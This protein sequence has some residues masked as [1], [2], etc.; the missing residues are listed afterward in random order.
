M[1]ALRGC[2]GGWEGGG[3]ARGE[4][5]Y[6]PQGM[7]LSIPSTYRPSQGLLL[8][9]PLLYLPPVHPVLERCLPLVSPRLRIIVIAV[10]H[11][12]FKLQAV[13]SPVSLSGLLYAPA[14]ADDVVLLAVHTLLHLGLH[15]HAHQATSPW[16]CRV[17]ALLWWLHG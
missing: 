9:Q 11:R 1:L 16:V 2:V 14:V 6:L 10:Q 3:G 7:I 13:T 17:L 12:N 15:H 5:G 8:R 4:G